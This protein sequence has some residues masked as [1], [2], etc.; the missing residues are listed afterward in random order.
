V[1]DIEVRR[2]HSFKPLTWMLPIG[3]NGVHP[4]SKNL[5]ECKSCDRVLFEGNVFENSWQGW[6]SDQAGYALL[7]TPKNQNRHET[8]SVVI[9]GVN[10]RM[11]W[12]S[13]DFHTQLPATVETSRQIARIGALLERITESAHM[14]RD[15]LR[16]C[17]Q[18]FC[19]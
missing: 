16:H 10:V 19:V 18:S 12:N 8:F 4:I 1:H 17:C 7:L 6:Q 2:N 3:G 13:F 15:N 5:G 11:N 9:D 14:N